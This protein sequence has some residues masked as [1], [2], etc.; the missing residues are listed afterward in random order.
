M[1]NTTL[2]V[3]F[4]GLVGPTHNY[5][6]LAYGNPAAMEHAYSVSN[7][8]A[9][10]LQGL[11]KMKILMDLGLIQGVLP[12]QERPH[13]KTLR[14]LGFRGSD[15][16]IIQAA[17]RESPSLLS[18]VF[19]AS[20]MWAAN[21]ATVA[22]SADTQDGR[23]HFTPANLITQ[24]HRS[25]ESEFT[26]RVLKHIFLDE[27]AF[28][29][30]PPL[31][32]ALHFSDEGAA[33]HSRLCSSHSSK[34]LQAFVYGRAAFDFSE[35]LP[36]VF[37]AR[38]TLEASSAI[39][40]LHLLDPG[41]TVF[42]KQ[43]PES[44]DAGVF[45]NDVASVGNQNVFLYHEQAFTD[46]R[47]AVRDLKT[48][49]SRIS[50][51]DLVLIEVSS[52]RVSLQDAVQSYLFNSQ[53]VTLP[54]GG[55]SVIAPYESAEKLIT[56]DLLSEITADNSNPI[57]SI[58]YVDIRQSM[59]NGGGPACLR[60]RVVLT[61]KERALTHQGV[62]LTLE[63]YRELVGWANSYYRDRLEPGDLLD[64][65]LRMESKSALDALTEILG[66]GSIYEFQRE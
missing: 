51:Q 53:L 11:E 44:I 9:A 37:P 31:I 16:E 32:R 7:P 27:A 48:S 52:N 4:D 39:A 21:A 26:A 66:L 2:E 54:N 19:S 28:A 46:A 55:M 14:G 17:A 38:Q 60:L 24:F 23:V 6:G 22:P 45:H 62:Y 65:E 50:E 64:P 61:E 63:L 13:L 30:H 5:A 15:S 18:A 25:I 36:K 47:Q 10:V 57:E 8:R 34:G 40:R 49:F 58:H 3:N 35:I 43:N 41:A 12:P 59:K 1:N 56:S 20:S 29:H 33:N 42:L